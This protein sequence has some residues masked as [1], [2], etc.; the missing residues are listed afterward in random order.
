MGVRYRFRGL[1]RRPSRRKTGTIQE[2]TALRAFVVVRE[3]VAYAV[4][5]QFDERL[6]CFAPG[7]CFQLSN[8]AVLAFSAQLVQDLMLSDGSGAAT[9]PSDDLLR[10]RED[11]SSLLP[12]LL[13]IRWLAEQ[14]L[15]DR[16]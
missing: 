2:T 10:P 5:Q 7:Y 3:T 8:C 15:C 12:A 16:V 9:E 4:R 13:F 1:S 14:S 6:C 11:L